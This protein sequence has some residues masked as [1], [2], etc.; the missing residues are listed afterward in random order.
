MRVEELE[1]ELPEALI[2]Q[3][4]LPERDQSR[5][6]SVDRASG[7]FE[8]RS[9]KELPGLLPPSLIILNDTKV[10]PARLIGRK[11]TGGRAE[12]LLVERLSGGGVEE[13]WLALGRTSKGLRPGVTIEIE[14]ARLQITVGER[15]K[16]AGHIEVTLRAD[17]PIEDVLARCGRVPLPPYIRRE[18]D[19]GDTERYQTVYA[20]K[21]G[22]VAAP[23]AGLHLSQRL[24][25]EL[26]ARGHQ[27]AY[28]TL[29]V[30]PGTFAPIRGDWLETHH[31]HEERYDLP[32][33]TVEAVAR[34]KR[35][36]RQILAVGTTVVRALESATGPNGQLLPG[37]RQTSLLIYPPY[38]FRSVD[39]LLTNFHLPR[40]TLLALVM[41][42]AGT[43]LVRRSYAAAVRAGYRFFSY[44]DAMLVQGKAPSPSSTASLSA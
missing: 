14:T 2:A 34:A 18:P 25:D 21:P 26:A 11:P 33:H 5:L 3:K 23:T 8:H 27:L 12:L 30:G 37:C 28:L 19:G 40:S 24:L 7:S 41:A 44:G 10:I 1:Y 29:H 16:E 36:G 6:L 17:E 35:E 42:F 39:A 38:H 43:D 31:M 9:V 13:R 15:A 20:S 32:E 4:P 22:A